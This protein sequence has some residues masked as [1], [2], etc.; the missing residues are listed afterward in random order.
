MAII[1]TK[2]SLADLASA[3][4]EKTSSSDSTNQTWKLFFNF[5]KAPVDSVST[6]RFLPDLDA[7]NP[8]GFLVENLVHELEINGKREKVACGKMYGEHC[9]IC[10]LSAEYYN[11]KS[12][13]YDEE[14][15]QK[16]YKKK[17][18]ISQALVLETPIEQ[19]ENSPLVW[20]IEFGP[21]IY[22]QIQAGFKSGDLDNSP[23]DFKGGYN[24]RFRKTLNGNG[25]NSYTTSNFSPKQSD[26]SDELIEQIEL[27][28]LKEYRQPEV[29]TAVLETMLAAAMNSITGGGTQAPAPAP[30]AAPITSLPARV[31]VAPAPTVISTDDNP[32]AG[33]ETQPVVQAAPAADAPLTGIALIRARAA[34]AKAAA[35]NS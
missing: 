27:Y 29:S 16:L 15:G 17:S 31:A 28:D 32:A 9:P 1:T 22:K 20:L 8:R 33:V 18:Y 26:V 2:R 3:F 10:D 35:N 11:K 6:V 24:F 25:S 34:A 19:P 30:Q 5:W 4:D 21:Q 7:E 12:P 23:I 14:I 13:L